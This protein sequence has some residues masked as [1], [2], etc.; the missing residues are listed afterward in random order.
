MKDLKNPLPDMTRQG[1]FVLYGQ[2]NPYNRKN[3]QV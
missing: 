2:N 3:P 1:V